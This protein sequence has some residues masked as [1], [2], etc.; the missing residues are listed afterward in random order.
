LQ[1]AS[2]AQKQ[3]D[4]VWIVAGSDLLR[5]DPRENPPKASVT[6]LPRELGPLRSVSADSSEGKPALLI[7]ASKGV[8]IV[9]PNHPDAVELYIDPELDSAHGFS[10]VLRWRGGVWACHRDGGLV[11]W[12]EKTREPVRTLRPADAGG[13]VRN[14]CALDDSRLL[15]TGDSRLV[16]YDAEGKSTIIADVD[17]SISIFPVENRIVL[18]RRDGRLHV[19]DRSTLE[20]LHVS[21]P[22]GGVCSAALLPWL[23]TARLLLSPQQGAIFCVGL[24]D[25]LVTHYASVHHGIQMLAAAEDLVAGVSSDRQRLILWRSEDGKSP[26]AELHIAGIA[27]HRV[28]GIAMC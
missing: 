23:G 20:S 11:G 12:R 27:K 8:M 14:L 17:E 24:D 1:L 5:V 2:A 21:R 7:G 3:T 6:P 10:R 4:A 22:S 18:V 25:P 28:A 15:F 26:A 9:D 13:V 19:F 16:T